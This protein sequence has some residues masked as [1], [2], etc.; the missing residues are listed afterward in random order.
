MGA[1]GAALY[2]PTVPLAW[3]LRTAG[4]EVVMANNGPAATALVHAGFPAV[5]SCPERDVFA[6]FMAASQRINAAPASGPKPRGG[7]GMFGEIM[8]EGLL[9][10]ARQ[11]RPD[12]IVSTMEQGAAPLIAAA[13]GVPLAEQS[14]RLAWAGHDPKAEHYRQ[15]IAEYL[16]PTRARLGLPAP[17]AAAAIIDVRPPSMG[18]LDDDECWRMRYVP[19]N[20][21]RLMPGWSLSAG[22]RPRICVT[23]GSVLPAT[24]NLAGLSE[25][26]GA[27]AD[28]DADVVL[29]MGDI[30]LTP[31]G[32]LP[33][34]ATAAGWVPLHALLTTCQVIVHHGGAGTAL[35][36]LAAGVPQLAIPRS[37]DQPDNAE[38]LA[39]RGVGIAF[40]PLGGTPG[41]V[42]EAVLA[43]LSEPGY[44]KAA[45]EVRD[46][47]AAQPSPARIAE[48]LEELAR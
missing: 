12:L 19:Y 6:E 13:L 33:A 44:L 27:L 38:V 45:A 2:L 14:V 16:Q 9:A 11:V 42:R 25:L 20:Q 34:N 22:P 10:L 39:R 48:R 32:P 5:D 30:D 40:P 47:I 28:L 26:L 46:E 1:P 36:A 35:T 4:H 15:A 29:A 8:A 41:E 7:L 23:M 3:A 37:A 17:V 18:G 31:A 24:G 43:L 21:A